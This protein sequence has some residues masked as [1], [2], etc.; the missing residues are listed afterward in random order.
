MSWSSAACGEAVVDLSTKAFEGS[1]FSEVS[2]HY[3]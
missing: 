2:R 3:D 1:L